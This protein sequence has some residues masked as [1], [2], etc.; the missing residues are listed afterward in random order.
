LDTITL[1]KMA[2]FPICSTHHPGI[3]ITSGK[4]LGI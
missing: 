4:L 3:V 2:G 1:E